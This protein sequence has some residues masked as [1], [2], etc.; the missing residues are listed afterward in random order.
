MDVHLDNP[1]GHS[2]D[3]EAVIQVATARLTAC[4]MYWANGV[5]QTDCIG[6]GSMGSV[7][8]RM[9]SSILV[10]SIC[11]QGALEPDHE[12]CVGEAR[13]AYE[14][15]VALDSPRIVV[16]SAAAECCARACSEPAAAT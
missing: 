2:S 1:H 12:T 7:C 3:K 14:L 4:Q 15:R 8:A 10:G 11:A 6:S 13:V 9:R 16:G 5:F